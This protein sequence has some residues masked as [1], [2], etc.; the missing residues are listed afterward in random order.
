MFRTT[1]GNERVSLPQ[2]GWKVIITSAPRAT[3]SKSLL[4]P[5]GAAGVGDN[6]HV[7]VMETESPDVV[8]SKWGEMVGCG[9][10]SVSKVLACQARA[11]SPEH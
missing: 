7:L 11:Q 6:R 1:R 10:G 4:R 3:D 8:I 5:T 2:A 9:D